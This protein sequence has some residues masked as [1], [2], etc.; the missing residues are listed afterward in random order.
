MIENLQ[1]RGS[2]TH[3]VLPEPIKGFE[4]SPSMAGSSRAGG[5]VGFFGGARLRK[6][7]ESVRVPDPPEA[8]PEP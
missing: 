7:I 3:R 2:Q 8:L 1:K 4:I 6:K 5:G